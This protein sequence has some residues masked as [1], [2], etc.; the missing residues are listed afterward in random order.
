MFARLLTALVLTAGILAGGGAARAQAQPQA[1]EASINW[2]AGKIAGLV[3]RKVRL[4]ANKR[5]LQRAYEEQLREIDSLKRGRGWN[6]DRKIADKKAS[7]QATAEKLSRVDA[8][9]RGLEKNLG[10]WR[11]WLLGKVSVELAGSPTPVR[12]GALEKMRRELV[13][14]TR[15]PARKII[16]PDDSLDELADPDELAEQIA[17]IEQAERE[18]QR[19]RNDLAKRESRYAQLA[20]LRSQHERAGQ[21]SELDDNDVRRSTG[22]SEASRSGSNDDSGQE[23]AAEADED[24]AGGSPA[25]PGS[26]GGAGDDSGGADSGDFGTDAGGESFE[27]SSI[28]LA[29]VVDSSTVDALKRAAGSSA[30]ARASAAA[31][32]RKQVDARLQRLARSR[33]L[34]QQHLAKLRKR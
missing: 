19:E 1:L 18:L 32:A 3:T 27:Q 28:I 14:L 15:P 4:Q 29:D 8:E 34:I 10:A 13:A 20:R 11:K 17:L 21:L 12:R 16:L 24:G 25:D 5:D 30:K 31:Q 7:S 2:G 33:A 6:R 22:R 26:G 23:P 9:L